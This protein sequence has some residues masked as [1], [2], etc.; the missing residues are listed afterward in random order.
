MIDALRDMPWQIW[1]YL[2]V[3][4][5]IA[6]W[7]QGRENNHSEKHLDRPSLRFFM[8]VLAWLWPIFLLAMFVNWLHAPKCKSDSSN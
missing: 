7:F 2:G 8:L 4:L 1:V 3:G 5:P 6:Y